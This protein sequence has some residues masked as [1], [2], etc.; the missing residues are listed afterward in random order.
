VS[1]TVREVNKAPSASNAEFAGEE[2]RAVSFALKAT[3]AD[4][5][6]NT[7]NYSIV[8][9]PANGTLSGSGSNLTYTPKA[10]FNGTDSFTFKVNDG[11]A[12]S[13]TATVSLRIA[14][15]NDA[16][17]AVSDNAATKENVPVIINV[18]SND[19]DIDGDRVVLSNVF[20]AAGGTV[21]IT[22][23]GVKFTPNQNFR[24]AGGF[25]YTISDGKGGTA[26]GSV[27]ITVNPPENGK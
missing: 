9:N 26:V 16:P 3:D 10:N 23:G 12:D 6:A 5:P 24:G 18:V 11:A 17:T 27:T 21:E 25:K 19:T 15:V 8:A 1:I 13:A 22:G 2:D 7:L 4:L 20:E 14:P